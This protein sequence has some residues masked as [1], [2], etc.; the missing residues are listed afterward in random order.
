MQ[1]HVWLPVTGVLVIAAITP[2]PNNFIVME[3]SAR[4]GATA[5]GSVVLVRLSPLIGRPSLDVNVTLIV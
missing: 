1:D 3:A 4:G 5:A 2:G